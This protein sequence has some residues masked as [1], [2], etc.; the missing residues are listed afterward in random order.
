MHQ[1]NLKIKIKQPEDKKENLASK[2]QF[3]IADR[4]KNIKSN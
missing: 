2:I 1:K 3:K 4:F